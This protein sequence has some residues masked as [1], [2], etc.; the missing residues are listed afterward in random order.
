MCQRCADEFAD[1][2]AD[3]S[4]LVL[5]AAMGILHEALGREAS[6]LDA[7]DEALTAAGVDLP[8][9]YPNLAASE[10]LSVLVTS[11]D[12]AKDI[13][14]ERIA[15]KNGSSPFLPAQ[16]RSDAEKVQG[17]LESLGERGKDIVNLDDESAHELMSNVAVAAAAAI[18][19]IAIMKKRAASFPG[20]N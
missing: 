4:L 7:V 5:E 17:A 15:G 20:R 14:V 1:I 8:A 16:A 13:I 2:L 12:R 18:G 9:A 11:I 6:V 19:S 3:T 10:M